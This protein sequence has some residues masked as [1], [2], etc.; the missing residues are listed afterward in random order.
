M[1]RNVHRRSVRFYMEHKHMRASAISDF[2]DI[3]WHEFQLSGGVGN[4]SPRRIKMMALADSIT[5][6]NMPACNFEEIDTVPEVL[7]Y[8][9]VSMRDFNIF[10]KVQEVESLVFV[11]EDI[12]ELLSAVRK[13]QKPRQRELLKKVSSGELELEQRKFHANII[14]IV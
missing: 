10:S 2:E 11:E 5:F 4:L 9:E 1:E 13:L 7:T 12:P 14:G 8:E 6:H 3:E